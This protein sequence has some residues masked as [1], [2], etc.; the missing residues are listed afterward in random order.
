MELRNKLSRRHELM[1]R[2]GEIKG[3][4]APT[5]LYDLFGFLPSPCGLG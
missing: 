1:A 5:A 4:V 3:G 2:A